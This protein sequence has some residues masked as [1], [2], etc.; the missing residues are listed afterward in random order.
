VA[1]A[2]AKWAA[3]VFPDQPPDRQLAC[4][5]EMIS[6]LCRLDKPDPVAEWQRHIA[7][8]AARAD[9]LNERQDPAPRYPGAGTDLPLG[10]PRGHSWISARSE[11][12]NGILFTANIPTEEVFTIPHKDR[13]EGVVKSTKPLSYGGT[14]IENFSLQF[15][16]GRVVNVS[17]DKGETVLR[18]LV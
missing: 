7:A 6:R 13:V 1:A 3:K 5:W 16:Q 11:S 15:S 4:L 18:Q 9:H 12:C 8:L 2:S 14:L 17:A 10:L